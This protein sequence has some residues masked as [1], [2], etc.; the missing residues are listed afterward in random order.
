MS[1]FLYAVSLLG[2]R[3]NMASYDSEQDIEPNGEKFIY[4]VEIPIDF[5]N[6]SEG[7]IDI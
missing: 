3:L 2:L 5:S 4:I 6:E 1:D 7:D